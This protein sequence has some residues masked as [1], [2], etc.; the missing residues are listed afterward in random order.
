MADRATPTIHQYE[1]FRIP[2]YWKREERKL[3]GQIDDTL[4]D[5][6][7]RLG[8]LRFEDFGQGF[9][10]RIE[11]D[12]G[13]VKTIT[14]SL[15]EVSV[16]LENAL[17]DMSRIQQLLDQIELMVQSQAGDIAALVVRANGIE[18][19]AQDNAGGIAALNVRATG[20]EASVKAQSGDIATLTVRATGIETNVKN[21]AN[22]ISG[23]K[24]T[25]TGLETRVKNAEGKITTVE[26]SATKLETRVTGAE[27]NIT[28]V[29]QKA[30]SLTVTVTGLN[31]SVSKVQQTVRG[32]E[33]AI[34]AGRIKFDERG[35]RMFNARNEIVFSQDLSTGSL[36][37]AGEIYAD[38]G[39]IGV[40]EAGSTWIYCT[41]NFVFNSIAYESGFIGYTARI[42][43]L[44]I[45]ASPGGNVMKYGAPD[46]PSFWAN[47]NMVHIRQL[48]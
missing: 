43:D 45:D 26:Q 12:E 18:A 8:R 16:T 48:V 7:A 24:Q 15:E 19:R 22:D 46:D 41:P 32:L 40:L 38:K 37:I 10:S 47:L 4:R 42:G 25:A 3:V 28:T 34:D 39:R 14:N 11:D 27:K 9:R 36:W 30:D 21:Q 33:L 1:D 35:L 6:Y 5:L 23:I 20:I 13:N 17:G 44:R 31:G 2:A 29:T